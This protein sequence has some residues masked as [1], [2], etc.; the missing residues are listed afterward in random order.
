MMC[1]QY[2]WKNVCSC[3]GCTGWPSG[4]SAGGAFNSGLSKREGKAT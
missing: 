1:I 2:F 3:T 4:V